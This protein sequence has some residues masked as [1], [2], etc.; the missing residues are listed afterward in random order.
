MY[1]QSR[2]NAGPSGDAMGLSPRQRE[3]SRTST[4]PKLTLRRGGG[5]DGGDGGGDGGGGG[6]GDGDRDSDGETGGDNEGGRLFF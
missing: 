2:D 6:D 3:Y 4:F 1:F 5:G